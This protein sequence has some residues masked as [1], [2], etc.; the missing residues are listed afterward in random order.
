MKPISPKIVGSVV[1]WSLIG[2][3]NAAV[4]LPKEG[5]FDNE[6]LFFGHGSVHRFE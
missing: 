2:T 1:L 4:S 6:L 3:G 5:P